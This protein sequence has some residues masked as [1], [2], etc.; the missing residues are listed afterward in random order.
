MLFRSTCLA[1]IKLPNGTIIMDHAWVES[2]NL[3]DANLRTNNSIEIEATI[4]HR[5]RPITEP[6]FHMVL[7]V[8]LKKVKFIKRLGKRKYHRKPNKRNTHV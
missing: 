8:L 3:T 1:N 5:E 2:K 6:T 4:S 7:D